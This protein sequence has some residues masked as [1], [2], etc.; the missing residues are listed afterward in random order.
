MGW[1]NY[2]LF[3]FSTFAIDPH[4]ALPLQAFIG[5]TYFAEIRHTSCSFYGFILSFFAKIDM[6]SFIPQ[7]TYKIKNFIIPNSIFLL[8]VFLI[9]GFT[10]Y[11]FFKTKK[12]GNL[13]Y[14]FSIVSLMM[15]L[16][17]H[18][19]NPHY[20]IFTLFAFISILKMYSYEFKSYRFSFR[21]QFFIVFIYIFLLLSTGNLIPFRAYEKVFHLENMAFH[22]FTTYNIFALGTFILW[23]LMLWIYYLDYKTI[24]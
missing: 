22:Y 24:R 8:T 15:L 16:L 18:H 21:L 1:Q 20:Y 7:V 11:L 12:R 4:V 23:C 9:F 19:V 10:F 13:L 5:K 14:E 3:N 17:P 6:S 2:Q